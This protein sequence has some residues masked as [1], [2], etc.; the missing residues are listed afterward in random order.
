MSDVVI[1]KEPDD[2]GCLRV[3]MGG[4][5]DTGYYLVYRGDLADIKSMVSLLNSKLQG[6]DGV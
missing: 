2:P 5:T 1:I 4:N 3:S 6:Y